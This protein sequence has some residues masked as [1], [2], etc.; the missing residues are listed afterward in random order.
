MSWSHEGL[1]DDNMYVGVTRE[2]R[3][4]SDTFGEGGAAVGAPF[5]GLH[6]GTTSRGRAQGNDLADHVVDAEHRRAFDRG[7]TYRT[8]NAAAM[9]TTAAGDTSTAARG[10]HPLP[11]ATYRLHQFVSPHTNEEWNTKNAE[12]GVLPATLTFGRTYRFKLQAWCSGLGL[13]AGTPGA[14]AGP[15]AGVGAAGWGAGPLARYGGRASFSS[16]A[17]IDV[18][19]NA[20]PASG[21][22]TA[23]PRNGVALATRFRVGAEGWT[24][25]ASD[26]PLRYSFWYRVRMNTTHPAGPGGT[27]YA[28]RGMLPPV[29]SG[30]SMVRSATVSVSL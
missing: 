16:F 29:A 5:G 4:G 12:L 25:D 21:H 19:A 20:P 14:G 3:R 10:Q 26:L 1:A 7:L 23:A 18:V 22:V 24:D 9:L 28:Y 13:L 2:A 17:E 27:W 15:A 6:L 30:A 8:Q 11:R